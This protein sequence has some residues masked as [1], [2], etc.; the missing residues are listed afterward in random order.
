MT[1]KYSNED[2]N[3]DLNIDAKLEGLDKLAER[4]GLMRELHHLTQETAK[5]AKAHHDFTKDALGH[6]ENIT[7]ELMHQIAMKQNENG[8]DCPDCGTHNPKGMSSSWGGGIMVEPNDF[9]NNQDAECS[10][11]GE[12]HP[13]GSLSMNGECPNCAR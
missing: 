11:C 2:G 8:C 13:I 3:M 9:I 10:R 5:L 12:Q 7:N 4:V 1:F 6:H